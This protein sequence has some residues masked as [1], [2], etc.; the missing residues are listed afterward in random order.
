MKKLSGPEGITNP[1]LKHLPLTALAYIVEI[2]GY[3]IPSKNVSPT[4]E[5][6]QSCHDPRDR[7]PPN[8]RSKFIAI[9]A[10]QSYLGKI[11]EALNK[12][13]DF[14]WRGRP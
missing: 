14:C 1:M 3:D 4:L 6:F 10:Y 8:I 11:A 7:P 2:D 12:V 13:A 5:T 9:E